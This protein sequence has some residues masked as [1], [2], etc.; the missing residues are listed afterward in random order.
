MKSA[1]KHYVILNESQL[2]N[3]NQIFIEHGIRPKL[4]LSLFHRNRIPSPTCNQCKND[5]TKNYAHID[6]SG[7]KFYRQ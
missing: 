2:I 3:I 5:D 1:K 6:L 4:V 7:Y